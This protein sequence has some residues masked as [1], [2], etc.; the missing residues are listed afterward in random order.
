MAT[1]RFYRGELLLGVTEVD[2]EIPLIELA[3]SVALEA[4]VFSDSN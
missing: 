2:P 1:V 4:E 3:E